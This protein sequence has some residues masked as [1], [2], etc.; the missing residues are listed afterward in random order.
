M[1]SVRD[2]R[3]LSVCGNAQE[4]LGWAKHWPLDEGSPLLEKRTVLRE[5]LYHQDIYV[6]YGSYFPCSL[7]KPDL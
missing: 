4:G 6:T 3:A 2:G 5:T 1:S 7:S